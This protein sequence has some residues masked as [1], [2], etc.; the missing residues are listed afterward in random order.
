MKAPKTLMNT[1]ALCAPADTNR[2]GDASPAAV[3]EIV[4]FRLANGVT[5]NAFLDATR[6]MQ[7]LVAA[8][9]GFVSRRLSKNEDGSWTDYVTWTDMARARSAAKTIFANPETKPFIDAID[10]ASVDMRHEAILMQ[11]E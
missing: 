7:P 6:G 1:G 4:R 9:P 3:A 8:T 11:M 10:G 5:E 2:A